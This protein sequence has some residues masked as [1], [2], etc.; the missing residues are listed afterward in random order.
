MNLSSAII[1][2]AVLSAVERWTE[3]LPGEAL[4]RAYLIRRGH[5][6]PML[7]GRDA[8]TISERAFQVLWLKNHINKRGPKAL[9]A[10]QAA[11]LAA[12]H[13]ETETNEITM[14][15]SM[16]FII[17]PVCIDAVKSTSMAWPSKWLSVPN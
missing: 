2:E 11:E 7:V 13:K 16:A 10:K 8:L 14:A 3:P 15:T 4:P 9:R 1:V 6:E 12:L 17:P 5:G